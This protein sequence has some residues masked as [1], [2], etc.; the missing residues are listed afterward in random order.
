M[1][2][3]SGQCIIVLNSISSGI[4]TF[5]LLIYNAGK[6]VS[7]FTWYWVLGAGFWEMLLKCATYSRNICNGRC[8]WY[9]DLWCGISVSEQ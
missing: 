6:K 8:F 5:D 2:H 7:F 1:Y 9:N 3:D 4:Y